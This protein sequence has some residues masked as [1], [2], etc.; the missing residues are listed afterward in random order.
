MMIGIRKQ[1]SIGVDARE[2]R[3][4]ALEA[5]RRKI[6]MTELIRSWLRAD[7]ERAKR[8]HSVSCN[9]PAER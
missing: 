2:Y 1:L 9:M 6:P 7:I 3:I 4:V 8:R 5:A